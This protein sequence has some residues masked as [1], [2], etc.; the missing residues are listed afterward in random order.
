MTLY[1]VEFQIM[2]KVYVQTG[3]VDYTAVIMQKLR[4][5]VCETDNMSTH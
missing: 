1:L 5:S 4:M 3:A 2:H